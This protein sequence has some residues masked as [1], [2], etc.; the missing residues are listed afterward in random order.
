MLYCEIY[1]LIGVSVIIIGCVVCLL[2]YGYGGYVVVVVVIV[3]IFEF[4]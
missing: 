3:F 4:M 2:E 1:E